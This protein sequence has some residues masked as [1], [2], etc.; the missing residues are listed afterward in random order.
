MTAI[1]GVRIER[2]PY[3]QVRLASADLLIASGTAVG[4]GGAGRG[5]ATNHVLL[6][7]PLLTGLADVR[8]RTSRSGCGFCSTT[9]LAWHL[10]SVGIE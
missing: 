8:Q 4:L 5:H 3:H 1:R 9:V 7:A 2:R 10:T 6:T